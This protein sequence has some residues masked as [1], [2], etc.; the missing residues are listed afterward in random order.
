MSTSPAAPERDAGGQRVPA[1][2]TGQARAPWWATLGL[3]GL[4]A[5]SYGQTLGFDLVLDDH[6]LVVSNPFLRGR[7]GW[8]DVLTSPPSTYLGQMFGAD[9]M[10]R[11]L[12]APIAAAD[13]AL[14]GMRP[15]LFHLSSVLAH[16]GVV[17]LVARLGRRLTGS[18]AAGFAAAA[19]LAVHPSAVEAVAMLSARMDVFVGLGMAAV[20]LLLRG[21]LATHGGWRLGGALLTFAFALAAKETAMAIPAMVTWTAWVCPRWFA[22]ADPG[23]R[24][25]ALTSLAAAFWVGLGLYAGLR[26]AVMG[27]LSPASL[28]LADLPAQ[29]LRA[30]VAVATYGQM[31][32]IPRPSTGFLIVGTVA[33]P[34]GLHDARV[35]AGLSL[36]ALLAAGLLSLRRRH[37]PSALAL[38]WYAL[39]LL[40]TSNLVPVHWEQAVYVAERSLYPALVGWCLFLAAGFPA[41]VRRVAGDARRTRVLRWAAGVAC[42]GTFLAV[43]LGKVG[44]WRDDVTLWTAAAAANADSVEIRL[45]LA[46]ALA[47]SGNAAAA[48]TAVREAAALEPGHPDVAFVAGWVA[49]LRGDPAEAL[50]DYERA[51]RLGTRIG[52]AF[53]QAALLAAQL[54]HWDRADGWFAAA[55]ERYPRAAWPQVGLGWSRQR[56]GRT[57][58]ARAHLERAARLEPAS[59][60]RPWL[61][62]RLLGAEGRLREAGAAHQA[63]LALDPLFLPARRELA[64]LAERQGR[65]AEAAGHWRRIA[66]AL[67]GHLRR[68]ALAQVRRLEAAGDRGAPGT[69]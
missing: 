40:P 16:L 34:A 7:V 57:D 14:W 20:L 58:L 37:P 55:A 50:R 51:I 65:L 43:T 47:Q 13:R 52:Q 35:L 39:A 25:G 38:G 66:S 32:L 44:A 10:Y 49:E 23:P 59:P 18:A 30:M 21:C 2:G 1:A 67:P 5:L 4:V 9:R 31:T 11:P 33:P 3:I 46:S 62:G 68:E 26:H 54:H 28:R 29:A 27:S 24:R 64:A 53:R 42:V 41:L 15:G 19:L 17:L 61:L 36:G 48:S 22:A 8:W 6:Y 69:P 56:E 12:M 63:A 45:N 60:E